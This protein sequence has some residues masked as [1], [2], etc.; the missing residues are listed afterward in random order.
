MICLFIY[1]CARA[2][3]LR[4]IGIRMTRAKLIFIFQLFEIIKVENIMQAL[5]CSAIPLQFWRNCEGEVPLPHGPT[6]FV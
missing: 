3:N 5:F 4:K 6:I 2:A 1:Q